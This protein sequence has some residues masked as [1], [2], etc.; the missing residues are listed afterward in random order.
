[1]NPS[2]PIKVFIGYDKSEIP[3]YHA[4]SQS[5]IDNSSVPVSITPLK[6]EQLSGV[7]NRPRDPKESTEFSMTRFLVPYL[8]NYS[9]WAI[10]MDCDMLCRGDIAELYNM[11]DNKYSV[12]VVQHDYVPKN[13]S[14]MLGAEQTRYEKKNWSSLML[15]NT[16]RCSSLTVNY[17]NNAT[18]LQLHQFKWLREESLIGYLPVHWNWLVGEYD[19]NPDARMAHYTL[20][21]PWWGDYVC[22]DYADEWRMVHSKVM[23]CDGVPK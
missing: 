15:M 19:Y 16:G 2:E 17:V 18:G 7:Y 21:G 12:M 22:A 5:I 4:L 1:M 6:R 23:T 3:A 8:C 20:G 11:K 9:G 14:K 10:F 13:E